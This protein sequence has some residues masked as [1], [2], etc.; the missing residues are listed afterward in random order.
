VGNK[1]FAEYA[2]KLVG[3]K[4]YRVV[5]YRDIVTHLPFI[6]LGY[7]HIS[8]EIWY[9]DENS[10]HYKICDPS[11][12]D[13]TCGDSILFLDAGDHTTYLNVSSDCN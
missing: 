12:E 8:Q 5:H 13:F 3:E 4:T 9:G 10:T 7:H 11:G 2:N 1:A 6:W